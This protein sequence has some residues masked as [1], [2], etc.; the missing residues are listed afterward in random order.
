LE[1]AKAIYGSK[2]PVMTA[3][4]HETDV[5]IADLVADVR[6]S[7]PMDAGARLGESWD[8]A[9][10]RIDTIDGNIISSFKNTCRELDK[11]L[12]IYGDSFVSSFARALSQCKRHVESHQYALMRCFRDVLRRMRSI[13][14]NFGYNYERFTNRLESENQ[15]LNAQAQTLLSEAGHFFTRLE[16]SLSSLEE[17]F[18]HSYTRFRR[19]LVSLKKDI[20]VYDVEIQREAKR[21]YVS[22]GKKIADC[23]QMLLACD[24]HLK[25]KQGFSIVKDKSGKVLK[26]ISTVAR[27]D[28]IHVELSDGILDSTVEDIR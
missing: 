10:E 3:I 2:I 17:Q 4:G 8:K 27:H 20:A 7:V 15:A 28:I 9:A 21:W 13:E 1:V 5:T 12:N 16:T 14:A 18:D 23:E 24:P 25:L 6:A 22:I 19:Y 26:S 11:A